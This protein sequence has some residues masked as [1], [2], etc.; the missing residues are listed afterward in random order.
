[1]QRA[2]CCSSITWIVSRSTAS[3]SKAPYSAKF[4]R[5]RQRD[6]RPIEVRICV[7][8]CSSQQSTVPVTHCVNRTQPGRVNHRVNRF[9]KRCQRRHSTLASSMTPSLLVILSGFTTKQDAKR[10]RLVH[11]ES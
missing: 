6:S 8:V 11:Q 10:G 2:G 3:Q 4:S 9:I 7:M 5:T 1:A